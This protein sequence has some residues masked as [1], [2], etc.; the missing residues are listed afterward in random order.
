MKEKEKVKRRTWE[1]K[2]RAQKFE[3]KRTRRQRTR[4]DKD[5]AAL[6]EQA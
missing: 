1:P 3:D 2:C 5:R 4:S 6:K